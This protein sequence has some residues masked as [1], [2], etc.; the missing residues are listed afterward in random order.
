MA[1]AG[2][3]GCSVGVPRSDRAGSFRSLGVALGA[4]QA[5]QPSAGKRMLLTSAQTDSIQT[6]C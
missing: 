2:S 4:V 5:D 1:P 3:A 6:T